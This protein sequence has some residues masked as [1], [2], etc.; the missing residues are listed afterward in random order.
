MVQNIIFPVN[1]PL[2]EKI[3]VIWKLAAFSLKIKKLEFV[4]WFFVSFIQHQ[5]LNRICVWLIQSKY[6]S[7]FKVWDGWTDLTSSSFLS[8][9]ITFV[10][11][12]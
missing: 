4:I 11:Y 12:Y 3:F 10:V 1:I 9:Y 6:C 7:S 8:G 5:K 2:Q